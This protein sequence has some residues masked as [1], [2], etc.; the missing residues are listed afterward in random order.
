MLLRAITAVLGLS[1]LYAVW[2]FFK[3][4]GIVIL[5]SLVSFICALEFSV[6]VEKDSRW[7]RSLFVALTYAFFLAFT[8]LSQSFLIFLIC[9]IVMA[10]YF[11]LFST[12][13]NE[14]KGLKLNS[15]IM[16]MI[17]CGA[18]T[19]TVTQGVLKFDLPYFLALII[20][21]FGTD[22]FA[23]LGGRFFGKR[24]LA[25]SISPNK[26]LEGSL[27]GLIF[28]S[29]LGFLYLS[30]LS[31][32]SPTYLLIICCVLISIFSQVGD[33]FES[34]LKRNSG[35]KDSGKMM[36]GHGGVLDRIDGLL[37]AGPALYMWMLF[38]LQ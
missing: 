7:I 35:V 36:P 2:Y 29:G 26:T 8:F 22:T 15:W 6:M 4:N 9:F 28:G 25:P 37:F 3:A 27:T 20:L 33:L 18:L 10:T 38:F 5:C 1:L 31:H 32:K 24:K 30:Q 16:G 13:T 11:V 14:K 34:L 12:D 19:G 23:Y 17:Y 21:S